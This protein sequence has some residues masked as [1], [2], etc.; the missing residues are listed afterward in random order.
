MKG[1]I[2]KRPLKRKKNGKTQYRYEVYYDGP[3]KWDEKKQKAVRNQ[4][5]ETVSTRKEA[6]KLLAERASQ[7]YQGSFVEP[8]NIP[9][10][11]LH[12]IW[13]D[14]Y[15]AG[16]QLEQSTL[17]LYE[18]LFRLHILPVFNDVNITHIGVADIQRF[19]SQLLKKQQHNTRSNKSLSAQTVKHCLKL[20]RQ[21]MDY[22]VE[23]EYIRTNPCHK[24]KDPIV[25]N[26]EMSYLKPNDVRLLLDAVDEEWYCAILT[27]ISGGLRRGEL[28]A[29]KWQYINW[30]THQYFVRET[31]KKRKKGGPLML[32]PPKTK[33]SVAPVDLS[34]ACMD[35]LKSHRKSQAELKLKMGHK[36]QDQ[37]LIFATQIGTIY[38]PENFVNRYFKPALK[39][40][41]LPLI[42]FHGLRH[43]CAALL[44]HQKASPKFI[45]KQMRHA[46]ITTTF[47]IYGHLISEQGKAEMSK[48]DETLFVRES[49][50][51]S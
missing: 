37:N 48:L 5:C 14:E 7:I 47:D 35:A 16:A 41:G 25:S 29:M 19:K 17:N 2:K 31:V 27:T 46:S 28:L 44:I 34:P 18:Y 12:K 36:Y 26:R 9:F 51:G 20:V 11:K 13:M 21:M 39:K 3:P 45:Q 38:N 6:E 33:P 49:L 43:T 24:V 15:V 10:S 1:H 32:G 8:Q 42:P 50:T 23:C 30:E 4:K 22:A 40:A